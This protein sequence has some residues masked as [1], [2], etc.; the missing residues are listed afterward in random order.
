M[1]LFEEV[2]K[3]NKQEKL[4]VNGDKIIVG[5]SGGPDSVFMTEMLL[6]LKKEIDFEIVL[7][8][9]NHLLRGEDANCDEAFCKEYAQKN[10]LEIY[11]RRINVKGLEKER[12]ITLEEAGR[13]ARYDMYN[14]ILKKVNGNKIALAHNKDDQLETFMFR[15]VRGAG[16]SGLEGIIS[17]RGKYIRPI[18]E[19]YKKDI[20][21]YLKEN[22]I[23]F[24]I[25]KTNF[26]NE[27]TRNSIR[28][29]LIPF[30]EKRY[31]PKFKDKLFA[32]IEEIRDINQVIDEEV[33][34]FS[35]KDYLNIDEINHFTKHV[36]G[37]IFGN[38]MYK[39]GVSVTR[40][41]IFSIENIIEKGGSC[42]LDLGDNYL[43][44]K[45]Y[46]ILKIEKENISKYDLLP[47]TLEIPGV[48]QFGDYVVEALFSEEKQSGKDIFATNLK[49]GEKVVVRTRKDGDRIV[50]T[51]MRSEKKLKEI[52]INEKVPKEIRD[53]V[54]LITYNDE[55][56]WIAGVRGNEKY[57]STE[58]RCVKFR[59]RRTK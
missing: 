13:E 39:H 42:S 11:S 24:R 51:G 40:E 1:R 46:N 45:E 37:K 5:F 48:L 21:N 30:I 55:I 44:K 19:I 50:P 2:V 31:N 29:D 10:N 57:K 59:V 54:P 3:K 38:F 16:L 56:V 7:V 58:N 6:K 36:R 35:K 14:E 15:L 18:S 4:I 28:L 27:F 17:K 23:P 53:R 41:K 33:E 26:E 34:R 32:L 12:G 8:H 25:D 43:L 9:I 47:K 22:N 20:V 49:V 52:F